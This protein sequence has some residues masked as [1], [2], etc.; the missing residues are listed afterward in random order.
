MSV[1][2]PL[3][4]LVAL[5]ALA[6]LLL[7][8]SP[9]TADAPPTLPCRFYGNVLLDG[10]PVPA[11]TL[12]TISIRNDTY[13]TTT[14]GLVDGEPVYGNSTYV[15][16]L[17]PVRGTFYDEGTEVRFWVAGHEVPDRA[18]W[19][20]GG[21]IRIHLFATTPTVTPTPQPTP[22]PSPS[23]S[24]GPP[25]TTPPTPTPTLVPVPSP[26]ATGDTDSAVNTVIVALCV[27][28]LIV[29]AMFGA[30][31]IWKYRIRPGRP[32]GGRRRPIPPTQPGAEVEAP[33]GEQAESAEAPDIGALMAAGLSLTWRDRL[34]LKMMSNKIVLKIF[35][36]PIVVKVIGWELTAFIAISSL[37]KRKPAEEG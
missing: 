21:N 23:P 15:V 9:A 10:A 17:E 28:V 37:F 31:L 32:K 1:R 7:Q 30:Y 6:A 29:C 12:V 26:T 18:Y 2:G 5:V 16:I 33:V 24:P 20:P 13:T 36:N 14:P 22:V 19:E 34:M 8:T 25:P 4:I 11:G 35:S 27:G 3:L